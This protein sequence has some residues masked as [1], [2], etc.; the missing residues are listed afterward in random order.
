MM[1]LLEQKDRLKNVLDGIKEAESQADRAPGSV[2]LIAVS[3]TFDAEQIRPVL[4]SGHRVFGENRVE[5]WR[6]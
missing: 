1:G 2:Q 5:H 4:Q 3:K 6:K